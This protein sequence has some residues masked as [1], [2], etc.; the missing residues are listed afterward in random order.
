MS[1]VDAVDEDEMR[2]TELIKRSQRGSSQRGAGRIGVDNDDC[3][4]GDS[5]R[6]RTI[7]R[8]ADRARHIDDG[9]LIAKIFEIVEIEFGRAA[10]LAAFGAGVPDA[11]A[12]GRRS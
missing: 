3:D 1:L 5:E 11:G 7:R 6:S 10:A 2:D 12:V 9:E 8:E 4:I